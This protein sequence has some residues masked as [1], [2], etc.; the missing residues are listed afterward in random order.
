MW[1]QS[2]LANF[3]FDQNQDPN[4]NRNGVT[5]R[6]NYYFLLL[7]ISDVPENAWK[8]NEKLLPLSSI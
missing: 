3:E 7:L 5:E 6:E 4:S 2:D 1:I 8:T